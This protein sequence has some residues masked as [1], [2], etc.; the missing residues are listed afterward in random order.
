MAHNDSIIKGGNLM[1]FIVSGSTKLPLA[2][3]ND[4]S[5]TTSLSTTEITSKDSDG[6]WTEEK[7]DKFSWSISTGGLLSAD[8]STTGT[9]GIDTLFNIY[10]NK[11]EIDIYFAKKSGVTPNWTANTTDL[12]FYGKVLITNLDLSA[13]NGESATYSVQAK[14]VGKLNIG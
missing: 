14:G 5:L 7:G 10:A 9:T 6:D 3:S 12:N 1:F 4:A 2:F 11:T 13:N 8:L